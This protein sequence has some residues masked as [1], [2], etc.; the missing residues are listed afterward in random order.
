MSAKNNDTLVQALLIQIVFR[1]DTAFWNLNQKRWSAV[2]ECSCVDW[3]N[4]PPMRLGGISVTNEEVKESGVLYATISFR[5]VS[6]TTEI[7]SK[8]IFQYGVH[9]PV[10]SDA[11]W[12][13]WFNEV[14]AELDAIEFEAYKQRTTGRRRQDVKGA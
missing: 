12:V 14:I 7:S 6:V 10:L 2:S 5:N 9:E 1:A 3:H 11:E 8:R 13:N 4:L